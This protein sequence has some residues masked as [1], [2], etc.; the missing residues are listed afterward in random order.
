M[1]A[2]GRIHS[3]ES[4]GTV[5][6]PGIRFVAFLQGCPLRCVYCHNRDTWDPADGKEFTVDEVMT[7]IRKYLNYFKFSGGGVTLSGGEPT[8]QADFARELFIRCKAEGI[9]TALDTC[10]YADIGKT[11]G[12]L[13]YTDLILLDIKQANIAMHKK[14][15]GVTPEKIR[16]FA[17]YA[18]E[19]SIPIWIRYVL[20]PGLTDSEEDLTAAGEFI[21]TLKTVENI[22]VL[23]YHTMGIHKWELLGEIYQLSSTL[24]PSPEIIEKARRLLSCGL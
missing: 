18:S 7:E 6:G 13:E 9:H 14:I 10:G 23:P 5:D 19:K 15:T 3:F 17:L 11:G 12:L 8:L 2:K 4:F 21:N 20:V 1:T 22:E 24:P 16:S